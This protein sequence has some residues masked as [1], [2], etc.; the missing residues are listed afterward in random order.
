MVEPETARAGLEALAAAIAELAEGMQDI[1]VRPP[2]RAGQ[3]RLAIATRLRGIG[4]DVAVLA[5]AMEVL[6]RRVS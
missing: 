6:Q 1:A 4:E 5:A 2:P 3:A